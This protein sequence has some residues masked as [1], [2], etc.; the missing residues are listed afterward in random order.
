MGFTEKMLA[1]NEEIALL[2]GKHWT[3]IAKSVA[4]T[5]L[6]CLVLIAGSVALFLAGPG[7]PIAAFV[8]CLAAFPLGKLTYDYIRWRSVRYVITNR[9][10]IEVMGLLSKHVSD[11]AL[12]NINDVIMQQSL[13]GRI[14]GYGDLEILTASEASGINRFVRIADPVKFKTTMLNQKEAEQQRL[15]SPGPDI[16]SQISGL[17]NLRDKG[18]ISDAEFL[19]KKEE[20]LR[21]M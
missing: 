15:G 14:L 10:V 2:A 7:M 6:I 9:R 11:S 8:A 20:L 12:E 21:R 18:I 13:L 16:P 1:E 3:A 4:I 19:A 5:V 17:A